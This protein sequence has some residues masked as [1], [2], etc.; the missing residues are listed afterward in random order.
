MG[1]AEEPRWLDEEE[2]QAWIALGSVLIRLP[3]ALGAQLQRDAG[4]SHFE[5]QVL[6]G[7][8]MSPGRTLRMSALA[9]LAD[10]SL[11]RLSQAVD[12]LE[13]RGWVRRTP[14]PADG[15]YTLAI[16]TD[17]GW[18]KVVEAAPGHVEA[19][20]SYVF[21]PLTKAQMRQ[22]TAIGQRMLRAIDPD[23]TWPLSRRKPEAGRQ[24]RAPSRQ[25]PIRARHDHAPQGRAAR[26]TRP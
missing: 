15:R 24:S 6:S 17:D 11:P 13:K 23:D 1:T 25:A 26:T 10:G 22:L 5:Y 8:S 7:L 3:A 18:D 9:V 14:A 16:L 19:V 2:L 12:W 4:I 20:R 21:D